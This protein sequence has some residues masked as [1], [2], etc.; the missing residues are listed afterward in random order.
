MRLFFLKK[1][2]R[3]LLTNQERRDGY[4]MDRINW[5]LVMIV[6]QLPMMKF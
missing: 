5:C 4:K 6:G 3:P 2:S 1:I